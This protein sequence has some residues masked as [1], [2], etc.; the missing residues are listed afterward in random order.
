V[1]LGETGN[2][3]PTDQ[4]EDAETLLH[5]DSATVLVGDGC[6]LPEETEVVVPFGR[7]AATHRSDLEVLYEAEGYAATRC[8]LDEDRR[9]PIR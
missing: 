3:E 4:H 7:R 8:A 9:C 5:S 2:P 1:R 6:P